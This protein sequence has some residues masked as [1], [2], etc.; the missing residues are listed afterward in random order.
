MA[1]I[2][3]LKT[4]GV[5]QAESV[6]RCLD[7]AREQGFESILIIGAMSDGTFHTSSSE[8]KGKLQLIGA[9]ESIKHDILD[10]E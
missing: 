7:D 6:D 9:L 5:L 1:E 8:L 10:L 2:V 4:P 3:K